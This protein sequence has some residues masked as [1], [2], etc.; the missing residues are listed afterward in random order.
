MK[1]QREEELDKLI[2]LL[3]Q[4]QGPKEKLDQETAELFAVVRAVKSLKEP[5]KPSEE[6]EE[7]ILQKVRKKKRPELWK[8]G[9]RRRL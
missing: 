5:A 7:K 3:N 4:E 8:S 9:C 2:D 6:L 1:K